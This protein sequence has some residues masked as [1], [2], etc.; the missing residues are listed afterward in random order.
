MKP[1]VVAKPCID[2]EFCAKICPTGAID[3]DTYNEI[4]EPFIAK[5]IRGFYMASLGEAEA[6]GHYRP[7]VDLD[8]VGTGTPIYK[9]HKHPQW[10]IGKGLHKGLL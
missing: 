5:E 10:I 1:P 2:C 3:S 4:M 7:L 9:T 8:K 6:E